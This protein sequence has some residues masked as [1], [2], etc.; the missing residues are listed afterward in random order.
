MGWHPRTTLS[1]PMASKVV[2]GEAVADD[3]RGLDGVRPSVN[4]SML[5]F[6]ETGKAIRLRVKDAMAAAQGTSERKQ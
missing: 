5:T 4:H 2:E 3:L 6:I 1:L